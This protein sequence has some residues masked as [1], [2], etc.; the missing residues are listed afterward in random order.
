M[1]GG[2]DGRTDGRTEG[3]TER[4]TE[5]GTEGRRDGGTEGGREGERGKEGERGREMNNEGRIKNITTTFDDYMTRCEFVWHN[6]SSWTHLKL[7]AEIH[8]HGIQ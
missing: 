8:D 6:E 5:R 7:F 1:E 2:R 3:G 4:G